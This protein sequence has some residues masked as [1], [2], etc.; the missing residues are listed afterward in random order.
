MTPRAQTALVF[1]SAVIA[2]GALSYLVTERLIRDRCRRVVMAKCT[3]IPVIGTASFCTEQAED[4]CVGARG[5]R[6]RVD[7]GHVSQGDAFAGS[8]VVPQAGVEPATPRSSSRRS[9]S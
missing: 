1:A 4:I 6:Q 5:E 3:S 9:T 2:G 7:A 8:F